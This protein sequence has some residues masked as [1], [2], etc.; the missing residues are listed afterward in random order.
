M[1]DQTFTLVPCQNPQVFWVAP[2]HYNT[3]VACAFWLKYE[4]VTQL[5]EFQFKIFIEFLM[6]KKMQYVLQ[7]RSK[8]YKVAGINI[9][10]P[11]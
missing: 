9:R 3:I 6:T 2:K 7:L 4:L 5:I 1:D 11:P 10:K 8:T